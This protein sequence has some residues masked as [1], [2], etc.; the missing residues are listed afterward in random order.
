MDTN[1]TE[2]PFSHLEASIEDPEAGGK[3]RNIYKNE[4]WFEQIYGRF[5]AEPS[6]YEYQFRTHWR[7]GVK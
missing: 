3:R 6:I 7:L 5:P 1:L 2:H 4:E